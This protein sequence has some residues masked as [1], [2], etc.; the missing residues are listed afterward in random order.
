M[1]T[2]K[3][4]VTVATVSCCHSNSCMLPWQPTVINSECLLWVVVVGTEVMF[5]INNILA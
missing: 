3:Q 1:V 2:F 5:L 4:G